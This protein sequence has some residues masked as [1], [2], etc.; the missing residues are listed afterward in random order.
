VIAIA[1]TLLVLGILSAALAVAAGTLLRG[2]AGARA[3]GWIAA[4]AGIAFFAAAAWGILSRQSPLFG[5]MVDHGPAGC[6]AVALTFDDGPSR[7]TTPAVLDLLRE[8]HTPA[9]FFLIGSR[10]ALA[11]DLVRRIH[12]EGHAIGNHSWAHDPFVFTTP[13]RIA[14]DLGKTD[15]IVRS[16]AGVT[17]GFV[18]LPY[19]IRGPFAVDVV[20]RSGRPAVGWSV[21]PADARRPAAET[22]TKRVLSRVGP[23]D[24]LLLHD[25]GGDRSATVAALPSILEGL[26][27]R[28]LPVIPLADLL[29]GQCPGGVGSAQPR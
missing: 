5:R 7:S 18:R 8:I 14:R 22:I 25:G 29:A 23:G 27:A 21:Y 28:N 6:R 24:I 15:A 17:P 20:R 16:A 10:A 4:L 26:R 1:R 2:A 13:G 3:S 9:T 12:D 11:P 19:G